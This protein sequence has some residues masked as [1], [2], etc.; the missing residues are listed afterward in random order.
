MHK[1]LYTTI[2][3][4]EKGKVKF[5]MLVDY[6][7]GMLE[8]LPEDMAGVAVMPASLHLF[9]VNDDAEKLDKATGNMF[10]HN[11]AKLLLLCKRARPDT[12][13]A[14]TFLCT[15]VQKPDGLCNEIP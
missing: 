10:H 12:Q 9:D 4:S 6:V 3:Y 1:Y 14:V 13:T 15:R 11:T 2:D 7:K 8:G 5:S